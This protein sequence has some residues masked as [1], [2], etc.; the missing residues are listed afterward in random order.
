M[1]D[2]L[3]NQELMR[4]K[5]PSGGGLYKCESRYK[6]FETTLDYLLAGI[7]SGKLKGDLL[8]WEIMKHRRIGM[9]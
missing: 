6:D 2:V 8:Q 4:K 7:D 9:L 3:Q 5:C 1:L